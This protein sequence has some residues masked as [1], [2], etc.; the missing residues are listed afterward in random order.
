[1]M[2]SER[3]KVLK[4]LNY[5]KH[6]NKE[7]EPKK[8]SDFFGLFVFLLKTKHGFSDSLLQ[9]VYRV[10]LLDTNFAQANNQLAKKLIRIIP[11][12]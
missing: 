9:I 2:V 12:Y 7:P 3:L 4:V 10:I 6:T 8:Y 5:I 11:L 1:M